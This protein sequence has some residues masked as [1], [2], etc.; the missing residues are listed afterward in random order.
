VKPL[1]GALATGQLAGVQSLRLERGTKEATCPRG[2]RGGHRVPAASTGRCLP[3]R[4]GEGSGEGGGQGRGAQ[5][6]SFSSAFAVTQHAFH[7]QALIK[8]WQ[9]AAVWF[10]GQNASLNEFWIK[11]KLATVLT[12][13]Q[14]EK[15]CW[16]RA[17][18]HSSDWGSSPANQH[19]A[20][21]PQQSSHAERK[22]PCCSAG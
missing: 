10:S 9:A 2:P 11:P 18:V 1:C 16:A 17:S 20:N 14:T 15:T 13:R 12:S 4:A 21:H 3:G 8:A 7:E 19:G 22:P 6:G 5:Q